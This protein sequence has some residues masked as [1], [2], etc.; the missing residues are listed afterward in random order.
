MSETPTVWKFNPMRWNYMAVVMWELIKKDWKNGR[1]VKP[2]AEILNELRNFVESAL[3]GFG[4]LQQYFSDID[5]E[6]KN[7]VHNI[8]LIVQRIDSQLSYSDQLQ[9]VELFKILEN[10]LCI[11]ER[12]KVPMVILDPSSLKFFG[13]FFYELNLLGEREGQRRRAEQYDE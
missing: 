13:N 3:K 2:Q 1:V 10:Q 6:H 9:V 8:M 4:V 7:L 5:L 11:L 12:S